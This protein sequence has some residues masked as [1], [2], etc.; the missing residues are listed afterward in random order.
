[1]TSLHS[2]MFILVFFLIL[3]IVQLKW[4]T[5]Y[6]KVH[7]WLWF[8][9]YIPS[10]IQKPMF[11]FI[12]ARSLRFKSPWYCL[13]LK[14]HHNIGNFTSWHGKMFQETWI[15]TNTAV[16]TWHLKLTVL[17]QMIGLANVQYSAVSDEGW[18]NHHKNVNYET[19]MYSTCTTL[20][21]VCF[22]YQR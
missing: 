21:L 2:V 6:K 8:M 15:F 14:L 18:L 16:R 22:A 4:I 1:M 7:S 20:Q 3:A 12:A 11:L 9:L 10:R 5:E 17:S 19:F 13:N